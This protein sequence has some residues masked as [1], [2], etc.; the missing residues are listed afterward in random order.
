MDALLA[1]VQMTSSCSL[2]DSLTSAG[3]FFH[4]LI[5][6]LAAGTCFELFFM[7]HKYRNANFCLI[8]FDAGARNI[9]NDRGT[10]RMMRTIRTLA[11]LFI[12]ASLALIV[13]GT[14]PTM[15]GPVGGNVTIAAKLK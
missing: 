12:L 1:G 4:A 11:Y 14:H 8:R 7:I 6:P 5:Y 10:I 3:L 13:A 15:F 9:A 2:T